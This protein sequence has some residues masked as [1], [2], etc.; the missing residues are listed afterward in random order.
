MLYLGDTGVR[1]NNLYDSGP[2]TA[3]SANVTGLP[4]HTDTIYARIY[5]LIGGAWHV[6]DYSYNAA[7]LQS[8]IFDPAPNSTLPGSSA[9]FDWSAVAGAQKYELYLGSNGAGSDNLYFSGFSTRRTATVTGLPVNGEKIYARI[10]W[11]ANDTL[12]YLDYVYKAY[13][14]Q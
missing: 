1:S 7:Q 8:V 5:S 11:Y 2:I 6:L 10:Y 13:T 14:A 12:Q 9:T 3:T 4:I